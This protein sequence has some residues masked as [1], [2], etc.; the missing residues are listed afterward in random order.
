[1]FEDLSKEHKHELG[2]LIG[3]IIAE[4]FQ[5]IAKID[6]TP[7]DEVVDQWVASYVAERI[8]GATGENNAS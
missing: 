5:M 3:N 4:L 8:I 2:L 6:G 1:M 7:I